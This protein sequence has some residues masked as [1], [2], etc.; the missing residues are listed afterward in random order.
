MKALMTSYQA[1]T[2]NRMQILPL[3]LINICFWEIPGSERSFPIIHEMQVPGLR[4]LYFQKRE[5]HQE[6]EKRNNSLQFIHRSWKSAQQKKRDVNRHRIRFVHFWG[7]FSTAV[8]KFVV[9]STINNDKTLDLAS[10]LPCW[11]EKCVP[12]P[13]VH[14]LTS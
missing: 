13:A 5:I 4:C 11:Y 1:C 6:E 3:F 9:C 10:K 12:Q 8:T 14:Q 7:W 2:Q